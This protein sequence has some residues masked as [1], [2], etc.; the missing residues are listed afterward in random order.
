[1]AIDSSLNPI[2]S[3]QFGYEQAQHLLNRAGFGGTPHQITSLQNLG[4]DQAVNYLVDYQQSPESRRTEPEVDLNIIRPPSP[5]Q[6]QLIRR[7]RQEHDEELISRLQRERNMRQGE[8]RQQM[9]QLVQWWLSRMISTP[10]PLEEKLTLFWHGHFASNHRTVRDSYLM[11]KQNRFF[12]QNANGSFSRLVHGIIKDPAMLRFLDNNRN[13][14]RKPNE[15]LA[16]ELMELFTLGEGHYTEDDI[17][18]GARALTGYT[19]VDNDFL[20]NRRMHDDSQKTIFGKHGNFNGEDFVNML[21]DRPEC[22]RFI[23]Y[24]LYKYFVSE[25]ADGVTGVAES[26]CGRL[27]RQ[28]VKQQYEL[29]PVLKTLFKSRHFYDPVIMGNMIKGPAHLVVGTVRTLDTPTR[30]IGVLADSM[31]MMGQQLFDPPTVAGWEGGRTMINTS[32]LF[33]RHNLCTYLIT[34]KMPFKD[35]WSRDQI[36]YNPMFLLQNL[37]KR[38]PEAVVEQLITTVLSDWR[39]K[40]RRDE[41]VQFLRERSRGVTSDSVI[42]LLL[43]ITATPEYQLC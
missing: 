19:Y 34:G 18:N 1:M 14:K 24:K 35:D 3:K 17:K 9:R 20:F 27:G 25:V 8:D 40:Q 33:V 7:A 4:L 2:S 6:R 38:S 10:R 5:E 11:Y 26:V 15:N 21:L 13:V 41:W 23:M 30:N 12:R 29:R 43:L 42:G 16:R 37:P 32:T 22:S 39:I 28:L 36:R 31:E